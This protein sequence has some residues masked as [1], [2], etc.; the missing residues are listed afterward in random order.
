MVFP[1]QMVFSFAWYLVSYESISLIE[2]QPDLLDFAVST[3]VKHTDPVD[4]ST[5]SDPPD[6]CYFTEGAKMYILGK[7]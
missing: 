7:A 4:S 5:S 1:F 2:P 6:A 3:M